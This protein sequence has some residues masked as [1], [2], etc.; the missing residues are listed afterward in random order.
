MIN[1]NSKEFNSTAIFNNGVAGKVENVT[2][3]VEKKSP[4]QGDNY[5]AYKLIVE[6][7]TGGKIN[8]GFYYPVPREGVDKENEMKR[9]NRELGR[10]IT[11]VRA[12]LGNDAVL[13]E[14]NTFKE[15][16]DALFKIINKEAVGKTFNVF[17]TYGSKVKPSKY[18]GLRYFDFIEN[19]ES[20]TGRLKLK[21]GDLLAPVVADE[22]DTMESADD[23]TEN[24]WL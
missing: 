6:D 3:S 19:A 13:P 24:S 22:I 2:I 23:G 9:M 21:D 15:A 10:V 12:I 11:I 20:P 17:V 4:E 1:L 18:M 5:P 14:V 8:A 16:Y 7:E